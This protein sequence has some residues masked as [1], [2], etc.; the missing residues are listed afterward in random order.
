MAALLLF[1]KSK[2]M[3]NALSIIVVGILSILI[4][5]LLIT[6][7]DQLREKLGIETRTSLKVELQQEKQNT[8]ILEDKVEHLD[9]TI[10]TNKVI[11]A[12]VEEVVIQQVKEVE[13][14]KQQ[15]K[16]IIHAKKIKIKSIKANITDIE[17]QAKEIS[18]THISS[19]WSSYCS[20]NNNSNCN[21]ST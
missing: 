9:T 1:F 18:R 16:K 19:L 3:P 4:L 20:F 14:N 21:T 8:Q 10:E 11:E 13:V 5:I 2:I 17:Q 6:G 12:K 7:M 15:V